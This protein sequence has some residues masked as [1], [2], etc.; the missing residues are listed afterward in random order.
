MLYFVCSVCVNAASQTVH[1]ERFYCANWPVRGKKFQHL[2]RGGG[3]REGERGEREE[4]G[5][6]GSRGGGGDREMGE[7]GERGEGGVKEG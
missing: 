2:K 5:R 1:Q 7:D 6:G 4:I 3:R